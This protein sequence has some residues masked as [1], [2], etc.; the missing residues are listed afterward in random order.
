M[1][2]T[3]AGVKLDVRVYPLDDP[4]GNTRAFANVAVN[5]TVAI[6]NI[7]VVEDAKGLF[8]T[9]PQSYDKK[10]EKYHDIAFPLNSDLR[11]EINR[12]VLGE[13]DRVSNLAPEERG[14]AKPEPNEAKINVEDVKLD[15]RVY[16][17]E[18]PQGT[19]MAFASVS[20]DDLVAIRGL[21]VVEGGEEGIFVAMPQSQDKYMNYH[22]VA[23]PLTKELRDEI[24]KGVIDKFVNPEKSVDRKQSLGDKL[25]AGNEKAAGHVAPE[26]AAA[27]KSHVGTL[28]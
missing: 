18:D 12:A 1:T 28:E 26:R 14:Y 15:I 17:L 20:V 25:A 10:A 4:K 19:T 27:A 5:D 24:S 21:R 22:D 8:V 13:H 16:P 23:F 3:R 7:R 6:R 9:M 2:D 11:K